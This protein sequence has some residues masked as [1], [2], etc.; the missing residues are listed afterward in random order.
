MSSGA[1]DG[2]LPSGDPRL[3][4]LRRL[5]F[6]MLAPATSRRRR[7]RR[8]DAVARSALAGTADHATARTAVV[9][10]A[11]H[12]RSGP[13]GLPVPALPSLAAG[14]TRAAGSRTAEPMA[15]STERA[16]GAMVPATRAAFALLHLEYLSAAQAT[17]LLAHA[18]VHDPKTAVTLAERTPLEPAAIRSLVVPVPAA[19]NRSRLVA[20][21]VGV[22]ALA[23]G[24]PLIAVSAFGNDDAP[25]PIS[26]V[27]AGST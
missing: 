4:P 9:R 16:L 15:R 23:V 6:T 5:A 24:A 10:E 25:T 18:G 3:I 8:A 11:L 14:L 27:V 26:T 21:G 1:T 17:A 13:L 12:T 20:A 22:L 19:V 2:M 7:A